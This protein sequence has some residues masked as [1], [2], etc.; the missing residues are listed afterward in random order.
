MLPELLSQSYIVRP[1][2]GVLSLV[3]INNAIMSILMHGAFPCLWI[4]SFGQI[5]R[6]GITR[7]QDMDIFIA[8]DAR[9]PIALLS[10]R[11]ILL[12]FYV[13]LMLPHPM[14]EYAT[15]GPRIVLGSWEL[16]VFLFFSKAS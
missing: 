15:R 8:R 16:G 9:C 3:V 2:F 10:K 4:I 13:S 6:S 1:S 12:R 7:S 11:V 5:P 14:W